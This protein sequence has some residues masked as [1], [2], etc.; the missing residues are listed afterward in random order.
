[1]LQLLH[2][3]NY[4]IIDALE[5]PWREGLSIITGETGAGKSILMG[6]LSLIL[7]ERADSGVVFNKDKKCVVEAVFKVS[8]KTVVRSFLEENDLEVQDEVVIRRE[9]GSNGKSRAFINDTPVTLQQLQELTVMLV[10]LHR[11]FDT[12][13]IG[14]SGFQLAVI[15]AMAA[16][17]RELA[18][19][20]KVF[21]RWQ[22]NQKELLKLKEQQSRDSRELE[23]NRFLFQE[24]EE[25][26]LKEGDLE[27]LEAELELLTNAESI[28][29]ALVQINQQLR[30]QDQPV[31][32][33]IRQLVQ[34]LQ[35]F[36]AQ[37]KD[38]G[39]LVERLHSV[40][41][42]LADLADEA[43]RWSDKIS[44]DGERVM[45]VEERLNIGNRLL[46]KHG[47][48]TTAEL[49][50][51]QVELSEKLQS[52]VALDERLNQ[53]E[54]EVKLNFDEL[55]A[56]G[57]KLSALR[58]AQATPLMKQ[59]NQLLHRVGMP[60]ASIKVTITPVEP[61]LMGMDNVDFLFDAN[62]S[63]QFAPLR[64]VASGGELSRLMLC[65]KSLVAGKV[66]L[67]TLIFDEID[68]GIS[69][70]ASRQVGLIMKEMAAARQLICITH[71][72]Q[73]AGRAD[74]HLFVYKQEKAGQ[75]QTRIRSLSESERIRAIA[76]MLGGEQPSAAAMENAR[77][78]IQSP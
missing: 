38:L 72:P 41:L 67:P 53:L 75:I 58:T 37:Q 14:S 5:I 10:D 31:I 57:K 26:N 70:E 24:L 13:S 16:S 64:K 69:G 73:I 15:D 9:I 44:Y 28:K 74:H 50:A 40:Q 42:E 54:D 29:T 27:Q 59:V 60:N 66:D 6:A 8:G 52:V 55:K 78:M 17:S 1:M 65:I 4:A 71:Q 76:E 77:E 68:T 22:D 49:L 46:K 30:E 7:G 62:K 18:A 61:A 2:I 35:P 63:G 43:D 3:Q 20:Q 56:A 34:Q 25:V 39:E 45:A 47:A 21:R 32:Q 51:I 36:T 19:Y 48:R 12:L 11:Q 23:F 33:V